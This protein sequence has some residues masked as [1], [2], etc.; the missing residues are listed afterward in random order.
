MLFFSIIFTHYFILLNACHVSIW[1]CFIHFRYAEVALLELLGES[2]HAASS[3]LT[4]G[5]FWPE[6]TCALQ[7]Q[8]KWLSSYVRKWCW[9]YYD[10][11][12][13]TVFCTF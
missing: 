13:D 2:H 8:G 12:Q 9:L 4:Q 10:G 6:E 7:L 3:Q 11:A 1:P 5:I